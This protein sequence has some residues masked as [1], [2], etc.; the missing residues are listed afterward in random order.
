MQISHLDSK[1]KQHTFDSNT[2][3]RQVLFIQMAAENVILD[4][5]SN[6]VHAKANCM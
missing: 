2:I 3:C 4:F 5:A 1:L 6:I